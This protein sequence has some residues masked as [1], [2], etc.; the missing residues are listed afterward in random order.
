MAIIAAWGS[1]SEPTADGRHS[2]SRTEAEKKGIVFRRK[3]KLDERITGGGG[4]GRDRDWGM[5]PWD[6]LYKGREGDT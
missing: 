6:K 3:G 1:H 4:G 5:A 2:D